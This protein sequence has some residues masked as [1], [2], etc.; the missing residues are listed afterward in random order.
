MSF[1]EEDDWLGGYGLD[2]YNKCTSPLGADTSLS[3]A[4]VSVREPSPVSPS[5]DLGGIPF[6]DNSL[7]VPMRDF[8]FGNEPPR[9]SPESSYQS[10]AP[11]QSTSYDPTAVH[12]QIDASYNSFEQP[13]IIVNGHYAR[14]LDQP[15][16]Q[17]QFF[18]QQPD[19]P[20]P[21]LATMS[22]H[23]HQSQASGSVMQQMLSTPPVRQTSTPQQ[24]QPPSRQRL[25]QPKTQNNGRKR[26]SGAANNNSVGAVLTKANRIAASTS[27]DV[28]SQGGSRNTTEVRIC[29]EDSVRVSQITS[30]ITQLQDQ[31]AK[32]GIDNKGRIVE[33]E[34]ERA[35][36]FLKALTSQHVGETVLNQVAQVAAAARQSPQPRSNVNRSRS[37][38]ARTSSQFDVAPDSPQYQPQMYLSQYP[39]TSTAQFHDYSSNHTQPQV[40]HQQTQPSHPQQNQRQVFRTGSVVYQNSS[41]VPQGAVYVQS[42]PPPAQAQYSQPTVGQVVR[43]QHQL[44][45]VSGGQQVMVQQ[46]VLIPPGSNRTHLV[47]QQQQQQLVPSQVIIP[48]SQSQAQVLVV[49]HVS[50][51]QCKKRLEEKRGLRQLRFVFSYI[52]FKYI[53][54]FHPLFLVHINIHYFRIREYFNKLHSSLNHPDTEIP[55]TNLNDVLQRLLPYHSYGEPS[56]KEEQLEQCETIFKS[57]GI[58]RLSQIIFIFL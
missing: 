26:T 43:Q 53:L 28:Q 21:P 20:P 11:L 1:P 5:R 47:Q 57:I 18:Q 51:A 40:I 54:L 29:G 24:Q 30:E 46:H 49:Q 16:P 8:S 22:L 32:F 31:Q 15:I 14:P 2:D 12:T 13:S 23:H 45:H 9:L 17:Q 3:L 58:M 39:T 42:V 55:F 50:S 7:S 27:S 41:Q 34:S 25:I 4:G 37:H 48:T 52:L 36:I 56:L 19:P 44:R 10:M 6:G 38:H 35:N 33:L